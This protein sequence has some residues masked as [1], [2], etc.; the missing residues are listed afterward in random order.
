MSITCFGL[1]GLNESAIYCLLLHV[2]SFYLF[3]MSFLPT[4]SGAGVIDL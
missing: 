3:C 4:H 2:L 1:G